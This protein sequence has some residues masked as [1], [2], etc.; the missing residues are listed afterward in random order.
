MV[1]LQVSCEC[2]AA[3]EGWQGDPYDPSLDGGCYFPSTWRMEKVSTD[4][5]LVQHRKHESA[6][7]CQTEEVAIVFEAVGGGSKQVSWSMELQ[8]RGGHSASN[9]FCSFVAIYLTVPL[10]LHLLS[11]GVVE[12][13]L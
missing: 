3:E 12:W 9:S 13:G 2:P 11:S 7:P 4:N 1:F 8:S 10:S 5:F 6:D